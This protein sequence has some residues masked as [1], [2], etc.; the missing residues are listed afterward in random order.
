MT[1]GAKGRAPLHWLPPADLEHV[2]AFALSDLKALDGARLFLTGGTG[3][4]GRWLV[5]SWCR[6]RLSGE[7]RGELLVLSRDPERGETGFPPC[8]GL[9]FH[10][11]DQTDFP[12]PEGPLDVVVHGA[13][14]QGDSELVRAKNL[15]GCH[16]VLDLAKHLG[17]QR[18][19]L[20]SSGAVYGPQ[21]PD[22]D[23]IPEDWPPRPEASGPGAW[24]G[25]TK[26]A[27]EA[28]C[29]EFLGK[30]DMAWVVARG[31]TFHGPGL[32]LE[33]HFAVGD[34][35]LDALV[36]API[37]ILGDGTPIRSYLYG[38]DMAIWLWAMIARG[39]PGRAY[40]LG[41]PHGLSIR[42]LAEQVRFQVSPGSRVEVGADPLETTPPT[43]YIPD[44]GRAKEELGLEVR[45]PLDEGLRRTAAW[46]RSP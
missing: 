38:A 28:L 21:P 6:A 44:V 45:I 35:L 41:S 26:R 29:S 11:G 19:L 1:G 14:E 23:G 31:F 4:T 5:E 33:R 34:F 15:L 10:G 37:R 27:Q 8:P 2:L 20:L 42:D 36:G 22:L 17:A 13:L 46:L 18:F 16:R 7:I 9:R 24:Y 30:S 43:R 40:N 32:P 12:F 25:D 3:F 39:L